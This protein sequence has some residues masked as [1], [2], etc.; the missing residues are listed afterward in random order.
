MTRCRLATPADDALLRALLRDHGLPTWVEMVLAREPDFFAAHARLPGT[1]WAVLAEDESAPTAEPVGLYTA[2]VLD[3]HVDG[4]AERLGYLGGLRVRPGQ[5]HRIR[6]LRAGYDSIE[7]LAP[8]PRSLPWW[9]SVVSADNHAAR[10]LLEA[11]LRGL[12][13]YHPLGDYLTLALPA[14][15]G[16]RA[17]PGGQSLWRPAEPRDVPA[18]LACHNAQAARRQC[19]PVLDA[20][21]VARIGLARWRVHERAGRIAGM[22]ALWD[23]RPFRQVLARR[24]RPPL[25]A[26]IPAWNLWARLA[27]R[28]PLPRA[29]EALAQSYLAYL[30]L[31]PDSPSAAQPDAATLLADLLT[32]CPTP[33]AAL[34][35]PAGHALLAALAPL[36][37]L[38]YPARLY[39]VSWDAT[40]P[41]LQAGLPIHPEVALL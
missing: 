38:R 18:L 37:P 4:R 22:A 31:T 10:R 16:R 14:A 27:R 28:V 40:P 9:L 5:R 7:P 26:L 24:Y 33:V 19:A 35:L 6:H 41:A 12:P 1:H 29:G 20:E 23:Q 13:R 8:A 30:A 36:K 17:G 11:G 15:R 25:G 39:A 2:A 32:H 21:T 34:G 3:L